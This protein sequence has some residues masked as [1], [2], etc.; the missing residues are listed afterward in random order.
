MSC[1]EGLGPADEVDLPVAVAQ[2]VELGPPQPIEPL[3]ALHDE[4]L[5]V[6]AVL[7]DA[8]PEVVA[9]DPLATHALP[10]SAVAWRRSIIWYHDQ[11]RAHGLRTKPKDQ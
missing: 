9:L 7:E 3:R 1:G 4:A 6:R 2:V 8:G 5:E 11:S 10:R